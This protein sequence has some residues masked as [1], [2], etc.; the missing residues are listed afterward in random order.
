MQLAALAL[1]NSSAN[2][3]NFVLAP[4]NIVFITALVHQF[5]AT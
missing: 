1:I 5:V 4:V 2:V 3:E